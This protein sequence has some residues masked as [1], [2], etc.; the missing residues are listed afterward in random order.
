[1]CMRPTVRNTTFSC[2]FDRLV[3]LVAVIELKLLAVSFLLQSTAL[4]HLA[5]HITVLVQER[6]RTFV[7]SH[8][9]L[10]PG[11]VWINVQYFA[12]LLVCQFC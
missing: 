8:T 4:S 7:I 5:V 9:L 10:D 12:S 2:I 11:L 3:L 6:H 1:M